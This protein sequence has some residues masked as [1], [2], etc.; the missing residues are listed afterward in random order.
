MLRHPLRLVPLIAMANLI[1][2]AL[3]A[4]AVT[5]VDSGASLLGAAGSTIRAATAWGDY[6]G[7][8]DLDLVVAGS[9]TGLTTGNRTRLYRNNGGSFVVQPTALPNL[10]NGAVAWGDYD[11]D[12]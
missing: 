5:F 4:A 3:P 7:D 6:D 12:G 8:G 1:G 2:Y 9:S 10:G 11:R